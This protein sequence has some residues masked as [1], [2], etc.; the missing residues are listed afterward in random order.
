MII[1]NEKL[2]YREKVEKLKNIVKLKLV[3]KLI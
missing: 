2:M 1:K 3:K